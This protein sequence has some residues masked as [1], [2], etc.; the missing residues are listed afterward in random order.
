MPRKFYYSPKVVERFAELNTTEQEFDAVSAQV[1]ALAA[2]PKLGYPI[3]FL[4][5]S[6]PLF[7]FDVGRFGLIY[8]YS[9]DKLEIVMVV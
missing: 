6:T 7:R 4:I 1:E 2:N 8:W 9:K 3:P 5:S